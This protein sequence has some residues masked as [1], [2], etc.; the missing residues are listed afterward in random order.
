MPLKHQV[1]Y[2]CHINKCIKHHEQLIHVQVLQEL[3][4]GGRRNVFYKLK[5]QGMNKCEV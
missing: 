4:I 1:E 2:F 3:E 5:T